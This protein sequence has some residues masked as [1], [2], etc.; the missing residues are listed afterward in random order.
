MRL[1][2]IG[3]ASASTPRWAPS[4]QRRPGARSSRRRW[5]PT[6]SRWASSR[7][8]SSAATRPRTSSSGRASSSDQWPSWSA[9][10]A[11]RPRLPTRA[12]SLGRGGRARGPAL[13]LRGG[14][15]RRQD[16]AASCRRRS[17]PPT[18]SSTRG[19]PS[20]RLS[21]AGRAS[22]AASPSATPLPLRLRRPGSRGLRG[23]LEPPT[24]RCG[25]APTPAPSW[26]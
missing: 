13:Q 4:R 3:L 8:S 12:S 23:H 22:T 15:G 20:P 25:G 11:R 7:S 24:G 26:W 21:L 17:C 10:P 14:G 1:V 5:R 9:S 19:A 16:A 6:T 2:K 18:T